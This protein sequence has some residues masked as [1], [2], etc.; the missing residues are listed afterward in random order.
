MNNSVNYSSFIG[1]SS[2]T[3]DEFEAHEQE[4]RLQQVADAPA[5]QRDEIVDSFL[6]S[7]VLTD[8]YYTD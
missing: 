3:G 8:I 7:S 2:T 5:T 1:L 4:N 6:F